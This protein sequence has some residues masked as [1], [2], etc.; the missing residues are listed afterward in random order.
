M[1]DDPIVKEIRKYRK[2]HTEKYTHDLK[3]ICVALK[4]KESKSGKKV[5]SLKPKLLLQE[6]EQLTIQKN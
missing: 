6:A 4:E 2:A 3:K 1:I 5:V